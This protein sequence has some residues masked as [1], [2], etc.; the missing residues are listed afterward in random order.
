M[1]IAKFILTALG[2]FL[3]VLALSFC[4]FQY[5][6]KKQEE[7]FDSLKSALGNSIDAERNNRKEEIERLSRKM[8]KLE[9]IVFR[10]F[11][12]RLASIEG[13]LRAIKPNL[14]KIQEWFIFNKPA[15]K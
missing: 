6:R 14:E 15:G 11:E 7:K 1:E 4:I 2:T 13:L 10:N 3:S 8:E 5:W 12:Q 9:E